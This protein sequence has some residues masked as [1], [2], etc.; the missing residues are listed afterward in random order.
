MEWLHNNGVDT[1]A[2][3]IQ[4][5]PGYGYGLKATKDIKVN[6]YF[7]LLSVYLQ[8]LSLFLSYVEL[9]LSL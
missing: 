1:S 9:L 8:S 4:A 3:E 7:G 6:H 2:V 5:F